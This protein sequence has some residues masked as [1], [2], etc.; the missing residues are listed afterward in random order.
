MIWWIYL[1][2]AL[3]F[4]VGTHY[5]NQRNNPHYRLD[6]RGSKLLTLTIIGLLWPVVVL[7]LVLPRKVTRKLDNWVENL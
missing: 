5:I 2:I 1:S 6:S 7:Y 3:V 4:F